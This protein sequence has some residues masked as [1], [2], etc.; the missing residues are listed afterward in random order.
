M[1]LRILK[2]LSKKAAPLLMH[3]DHRGE[4]FLAQ[5]GENYH[6]LVIERHPKVKEWSAVHPLKGTPM[7][8][9]M[10]GYYE[11]EWSERTAW[12]ELGECIRWQ[13][14]PETLTDAEYA[15][16]MRL[17]GERPVTDDDLAEWEAESD[18]DW[19]DAMD[20]ET[21]PDMTGCHDGAAPSPKD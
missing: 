13:E 20:H 19:L 17:S 12:D 4:L 6:G 18:D 16:A 1:N 11:P 10:E 8:G 5:R 21:L 14:K 15:Y 3:F 7:V 2:K 9:A